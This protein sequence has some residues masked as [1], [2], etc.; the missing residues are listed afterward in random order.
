MFSFEL[1]TRSG[2]A[3]Q[4]K[5]TLFNMMG[6]P[7]LAILL[8]IIIFYYSLWW[9]MYDGIPGATVSKF[10]YPPDWLWPN[11]YRWFQPPWFPSSSSTTTQL[12]ELYCKQTRKVFIADKWDIIWSDL[13]RF[14]FCTIF[15]IDRNH[16]SEGWDS[17]CPISAS[18]L[19]AVTP[20][21]LVIYSAFF[22]I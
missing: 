20:S 3:E 12:S 10:R 14:I 5:F 13:P 1:S 19:C 17:S 22:D 16:S 15:A 7:W 4:S 18:L 9:W 2:M 6:P 8:W 21:H 11:C